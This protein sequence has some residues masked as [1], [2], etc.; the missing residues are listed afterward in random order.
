MKEGG[1]GQYVQ[2][3]KTRIDERLK[4]YCAD[5]RV[6]GFN[7][8]SIDRLTEIRVS[9][10]KVDR[11]LKDEKTANDWEAVME[12]YI[13]EVEATNCTPNE[14]F[15]DRSLESK[16]HKT[17]MYRYFER[18]EGYFATK[19]KVY[20]DGAKELSMLE[21]LHTYIDLNPTE[22]SG[23]ECLQLVYDALHQDA[24]GAVVDVFF[25]RSDSKKYCVWL[26]GPTSSGKS[27]FNKCFSRI[28]CC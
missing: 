9:T 19:Q 25:N 6:L 5:Q 2:V 27:S 15:K 23:E 22:K 7:V 3:N 26:N 21:S 14:Y 28:F 4:E 18:F 12:D 24:I 13:K 20:G 10:A 11:V 17:T 16:K 1:N 8:D